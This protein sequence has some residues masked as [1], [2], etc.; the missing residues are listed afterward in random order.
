MNFKS[1]ITEKTWEGDTK[2]PPCI[3]QY[4]YC[5]SLCSLS[6]KAQPKRTRK[7]EKTKIK[8]FSNQGVKDFLPKLSFS[9]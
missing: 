3:S 7:C 9:I 1:L 6:A 2:H 8:H 5:C 4:K